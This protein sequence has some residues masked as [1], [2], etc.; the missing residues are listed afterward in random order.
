MN[1][2]ILLTIVAIG[3]LAADHLAAVHHWFAGWLH[4]M[5]GQ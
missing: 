4:R 1:A 2:K 5:L 3:I